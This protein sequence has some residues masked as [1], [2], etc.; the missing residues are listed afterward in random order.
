[1]AIASRIGFGPSAGHSKSR[2]SIPIRR[3]AGSKP[4]RVGRPS[5]LAEHRAEPRPC[6][7]TRCMRTEKNPC[8]PLL[9]SSQGFLWRRIGDLN[10]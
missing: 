7:F 6:C 5:E 2:S 1:M 9:S 4:P 10:P 3:A 8:E